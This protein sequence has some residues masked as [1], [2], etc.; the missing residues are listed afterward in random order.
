MPHPFRPFTYCFRPQ[1]CR[2]LSLTAVKERMVKNFL[3]L[4]TSYRNSVEIARQ[5]NNSRRRQFYFWVLWL[6]AEVVEFSFVGPL[7]INFSI[8]YLDDFFR[9]IIAAISSIQLLPSNFKRQRRHQTKITNKALTV[10]CPL[11]KLFFFWSPLIMVT[12]QP[13]GSHSSSYYTVII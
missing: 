10:H 3:V 9:I 4:D 2:H 6:I 12:L 7:Y 13:D 1:N 8:V 11:R 5:L